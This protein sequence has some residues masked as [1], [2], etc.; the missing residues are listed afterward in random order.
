[1]DLKIFEKM[2]AADLRKYIEFLLWLGD[3]TVVQAIE[4]N[5][6]PF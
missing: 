6:S 4:D 3:E 1:M 2:D 5:V